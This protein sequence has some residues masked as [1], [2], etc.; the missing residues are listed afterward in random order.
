MRRLG[1][2]LLLLLLPGPAFSQGEPGEPN[3]V[4]GKAR[5]VA[6]NTPFKM[7]ISTKG[8][9]DWFVLDVPKAG[10]LQF[11]H[12]DLPK[13][14]G[15]DL[16][17][18]MAGDDASTDAG[19]ASRRRIPGPMRV[20][21]S[22]HDSYDDEASPSLFEGTFRFTPEY[23]SLEPNDT[24]DTA[25]SLQLD[26]WY[27]AA[28]A[29][30]SDREFLRVEVP[31]DGYLLADL[32]PAPGN[33][34]FQVWRCNAAGERVG[35]EDRA[36]GVT[37]GSHLLAIDARHGWASPT[38]FGF[39]FRFVPE[40]DQLASRD[41]EPVRVELRRRYTSAFLP[42]ED[43]HA[44]AFRLEALS[45]VR[46]V[47]QDIPY[48]LTAMVRKHQGDELLW[49]FEADRTIRLPAGDQVLSLE[50]RHGWS[51]R[52]SFGVTVTAEPEFDES[53]PNDLPKQAIPAPLN[54]AFDVVLF[55]KGDV[56]W[57][58]IDLPEA[59]PLQFFPH[60]EGSGGPDFSFQVYSEDGRE[61]IAKTAQRHGTPKSVN[62]AAGRYLVRFTGVYGWSQ[63]EAFHL[64]FNTGT[65]PGRSP[66]EGLAVGLMWIGAEE[67]R[68]AM[69]TIA[70]ASGATYVD[71]DN[72]ADLVPALERAITAASAATDPGR[73]T[74]QTTTDASDATHVDTKGAADLGPSPER[75]TT[76][77]LDGGAVKP[78]EGSAARLL[79][80]VVPAILVL[81]LLIFWLR[82]SRSRE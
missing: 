62:L 59:G 77:T 48:P 65:G 64:E 82:R 34:T 53:E 5:E 51:S 31:A 22:I 80:F 15:L 19:D 45:L 4:I 49:E 52:K 41:G 56:E 57:Y 38:L 9:V 24:P 79:L 71:A 67:E 27:E 28:L 3:D 68:A 37:R 35:P 8:D 25:V 14:A 47:V 42:K 20:Y 39:R 32:D 66:E 58:R 13:G 81:F 46:F 11:E 36:F 55:P 74:A 26:H 73:A 78:A 72:A 12:G 76:A 18:R 54:K 16:V 2:Y 17:V 10:Y 21:L 69:E 40:F 63:R 43:T 44:V 1:L 30:P 61:L 6:P 50:P 75:A 7:A 23:D 60:G 70:A 33:L 29:T